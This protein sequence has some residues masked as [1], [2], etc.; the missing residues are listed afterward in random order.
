MLRSG[1]H[2]AKAFLREEREDRLACDV[3]GRELEAL[4][5]RPEDPV[6][7][8][9]QDRGRPY[10]AVAEVIQV[11]LQDPPGCTLRPPRTLTCL[12]P[13]AFLDFVPE[14]SPRA[15]FVT[16]SHDLKDGRAYGLSET[17][18]EVAWGQG[19]RDDF[20]LGVPTQI[21]VELAKGQ[22]PVLDALPTY[23]TEETVGL[24]I[25]GAPQAEHMEQYRQWVRSHLHEARERERLDFRPEGFAVNRETLQ[26]RRAV[27]QGLRLLSDHPPYILV[28]GEDEAFAAH[29]AQALG[30][31]FGIGYLDWIMGPLAP[32]LVRPGVEAP[33]GGFSMLLVHQRLR[34]TSGY[35]LIRQ[36]IQQ[37][38]CPLPVLLVGSEED[39]PLKR[40]RAIAAGAVDYLS[41]EPF[42]VLS[43]MRTM[44]ATLKL[45]G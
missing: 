19:R 17:G 32:Q 45:F 10:E 39:V 36:V 30:R 14:R 7:L 5:L 8:A 20:R 22:V 28:V 33:W 21:S 3:E 16:P 29:L 31:K 41:V 1:A 24:R 42:H 2:Q 44:E 35:E 13:E 9:F 4:G 18:L 6:Q 15:T 25:Q 26:A 27:T 11:S 37:E 34:L 23:F 43:V 40:N 38:A 12:N